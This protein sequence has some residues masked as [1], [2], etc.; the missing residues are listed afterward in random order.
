VTGRAPQRGTRARPVLEV[1]CDDVEDAARALA[2][3]ADRIE[4]CAALEVGGVTPGPGL[5]A[6]ARAAVRGE[7]VVLARPRRGDFVYDERTFRALVRDVE[8]AKELGADGVAVGVLHADGTLDATRTRALVLAAAPLVVTFH[9]AFDAV[10]DPFAALARLVDL[11]VQRVLTS[12]G[13]AHALEGRERLL[14]LVDSA[15]ERIE[16]VAAGGVRSEHVAAL[17]APGALGVI[18]MPGA[19]ATLVAVHAS[20]SRLITTGRPGT[21][22]GPS[23]LPAEHELRRVDPDEV[24]L[25]RAALDAAAGGAHD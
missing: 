18:E 19:F 7:L 13:G 16:V 3:G 12:G 1:V 14:A 20:A 2:R 6:E 21:S 22:L 9:R 10:P 5:L 24:A 4:L 25:L 15:A 8:V 23:R 17:L 11:G